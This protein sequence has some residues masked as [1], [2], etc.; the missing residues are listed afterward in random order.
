MRQG[1]EI[2]NDIDIDFYVVTCPTMPIA[3]N[4]HFSEHYIN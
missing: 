4:K 3:L 2:N 1:H